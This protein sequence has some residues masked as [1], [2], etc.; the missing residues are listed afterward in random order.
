MTALPGSISAFPTAKEAQAVSAGRAPSVP[1]ARSTATALVPA[2]ASRLEGATTGFVKM[3]N[4]ALPPPVLAT[5]ARGGGLRPHE[6]LNGGDVALFD[7]SCLHPTSGTMSG[8]GAM[9]LRGFAGWR[10]LEQFT[11][12]EWLGGGNPHFHRALHRKMWG[13]G[14]FDYFVQCVRVCNPDNSEVVETHTTQITTSNELP[15]QIN[16]KPLVEAATNVKNSFLKELL[17]KYNEI[18]LFQPNIGFPPDR[19]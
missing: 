3:V 19:G 6:Q 10:R 5:P 8:V 14:K 4:S 18:T 2:P 7:D 17:K 12:Q 9:A 13:L 1:F 15:D 11:L 16:L